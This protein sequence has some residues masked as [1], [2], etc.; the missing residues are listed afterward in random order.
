MSYISIRQEQPV[1]ENCFFAFNQAQYDEAIKKHNLEGVKL[2]RDESGLIGTKEG[3][4]KFYDFYSNQRKRIKAE[5]TPQEVYEEEFVNH[6]C[7]Y[8]GD[9]EE[10]I[11]MVLSTFSK[12]QAKTVKRRNSYYNIDKY[13]E[14]DEE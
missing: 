13:K 14:E 6:E 3:I 10:A 7:D 1:F 5:C 8:V 9:D 4:Q 11:L 12:E 2:Y